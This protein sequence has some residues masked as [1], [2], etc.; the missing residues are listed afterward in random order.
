ME[1]RI[2]DTFADALPRLTVDEQ[3]AVKTT[4]FDLQLDPSH[5]SLKFHRLDKSKDPNFW[6]V[7]VGRDIRII[8]HKT[9]SSL[10]VCFVDHHDSAYRWAERR[11][12]ERHPRTGA[13]QLVEV[14]ERVEEIRVPTYIEEAVEKPS[15]SPAASPSLPRTPARLLFTETTDGLA[16]R[17][18]TSH[19]GFHLRPR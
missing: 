16:A 19:R 7:R 3:K 1:F 4:V 2:A 11:R 10:L 9:Q 17:R 12:I 5:P 15:P 6:S 14:R 18:A 13:A 8:V